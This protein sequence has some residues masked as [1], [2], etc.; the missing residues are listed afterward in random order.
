MGNKI[1]MIV[2]IALLVILIGL[3]GFVAVF[4]LQALQNS[5]NTD[6]LANMQMVRP[7]KT[8]TQKEIDL[9]TFPDAILANLKIGSD[10][11]P[12]AVSLKVSIGIDNTDI[13][14]E[15][16]ILLLSEREPV[17]RD[18]IGS[19]LRVTTYDELI[20]LNEYN[21]IENL[22]MNILSALKV[23]FA[24]NLIVSVILDVVYQ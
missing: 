22:K 15:A 3:V 19:I 13:E 1:I 18:I 14:S 16:I 2:I 12:H 11:K 9:V 24:S 4:G 17:V 5:G 21:G 6:D 10:G 8:L 7:E 23:E 20:E